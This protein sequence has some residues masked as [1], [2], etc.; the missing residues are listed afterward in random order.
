MNLSENYSSRVRWDTDL[1]RTH[2]AYYYQK[3][4]LHEE[5][6]VLVGLGHEGNVIV[7]ASLFPFSWWPSYV[8]NK[9][10]RMGTLHKFTN[11]AWRIRDVSVHCKIE[12]NEIFRPSS[13]ITSYHG[14]WGG[15]LMWVV[16]H[17]RA[18]EDWLNFGNASSQLLM[19]HSLHLFWT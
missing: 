7:F 14:R 2:W 16:G 10:I 17:F 3:F 19:M 9:N 8:L 11:I 15:N 18:F 5:L 1:I 4:M 13:L 6:N 12:L